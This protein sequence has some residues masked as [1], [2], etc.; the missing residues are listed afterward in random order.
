MK[1]L[2]EWISRLWAKIAIAF[3]IVLLG[4][5]KLKRRKKQARIAGDLYRFEIHKDLHTLSDANRKA[6]DR[7]DA[8]DQA[9]KDEIEKFKGR[10]DEIANSDEDIGSI[11][12]DYRKRVRE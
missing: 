9:A 3:A 11:L 4:G 5:S 6:K 2:I 7:A 10:V 12:S 1:R 8:A